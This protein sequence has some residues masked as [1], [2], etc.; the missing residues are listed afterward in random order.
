MQRLRE[1]TRDDKKDIR[2]A[3]IKK[4]AKTRNKY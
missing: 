4:A 2:G 1:N 3:T